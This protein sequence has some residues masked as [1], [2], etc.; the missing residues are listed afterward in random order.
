[1]TDK[2]VPFKLRGHEKF[3]LREGWLN[4]GLITVD[5]DSRIFLDSNGPDKL[6]VGNNMVRSIRYWLKSFNLIT[7]KPGQGAQLTDLGKIIKEN[8]LYF[9]DIFTLWILHSNLVKNIK[10][11]TVWYMFFNRC[12]IDEF[13]KDEI[14]IVLLNELKNYVKEEKFSENSLKDDIDVL[15]NM[16]NSKIEKGVACDPEDKTISP[17]STLGLLSRKDDY[18]YKNQPDLSKL[19]ERVIWYELCCL[20]EDT[21]NVSIDSI[22]TGDDSLGSIYNLSRVSINEYLDKLDGLKYI[23]VNRTAGLDMIYKLKDATPLSVIEDYYK[24]HK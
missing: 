10:E 13:R 8:D 9:E 2:K 23:R 17:F 18:Y 1:M 22:T 21:N 15:L 4:K 11:S 6:G 20:F 14:F 12:D 19:T 24:E 5:T 16:Y 3:P 7:E